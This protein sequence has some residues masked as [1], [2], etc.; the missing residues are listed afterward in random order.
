M[1]ID[2]YHNTLGSAIV[3]IENFMIDKQVES[4]EFSNHF[5]E[6]VRYEETVSVSF[7]I[8][9]LKGRNTKKGLHAQF[10]RLP[11][12]NYELNIYIL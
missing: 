6:S 9:S 11:S 4:Q 5:W 8:D 2:I 7:E 12:G 3:E 1:K 10:Y